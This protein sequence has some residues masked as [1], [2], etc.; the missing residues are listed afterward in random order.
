MLNNPN[1]TFFSAKPK[2]LQD[3]I[4]FLTKNKANRE[5]D[6][7]YNYAITLRGKLIGGCGIKI[8]Q[9]RK[10]RGEIGYFVAE[11]YWGKGV[12]TTAVRMLEKIGFEKLK[13]GRIEIIVSPKNKASQRVAV[14]CGYKKEGLMRK[15][16]DD[17]GKLN[18]GI[19][20]AKTV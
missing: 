16:I 6:F 5:K 17:T 18:D 9:H 14:K 12:A 13:L 4:D 20:Y 1:F 7:E 8:D 19:L 11:Q 15:I 3:E 10:H 2:S